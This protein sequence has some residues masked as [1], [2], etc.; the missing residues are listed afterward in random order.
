MALPPQA[1][2]GRVKLTTAM[3]LHGRCS[4][5]KVSFVPDDSASIWAITFPLNAL[6]RHLERKVVIRDVDIPRV[7]ALIDMVFTSLPVSSCIRL[8]PVVGADCHRK[9][10]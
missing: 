6:R 4:S 8:V 5:H 2:D 10:S 7:I 1:G 3:G 9:Q